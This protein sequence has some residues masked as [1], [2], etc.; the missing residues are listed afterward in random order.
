MT[1][2]VMRD[3]LLH[4]SVETPGVCVQHLMQKMLVEVRRE[5]EAERP[6]ERARGRAGGTA[7]VIRFSHS[8]ITTSRPACMPHPHVADVSSGHSVT[9]AW[10][11]PL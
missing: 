9:S 6:M 7:K 1:V 5:K 10:G 2:S 11:W 8:A 3:V 4:M